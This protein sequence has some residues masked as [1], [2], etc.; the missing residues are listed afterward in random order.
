MP[1]N[2]YTFFISYQTFQ[3]NISLNV[4]L[5]FHK[6][7]L[8]VLFINYRK[9]SLTLQVALK[10]PFKHQVKIKSVE[11]NDEVCFLLP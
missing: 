5:I 8:L 6:V 11:G 3:Q 7:Y 9:I 10:R 2:G 1:G 4:F